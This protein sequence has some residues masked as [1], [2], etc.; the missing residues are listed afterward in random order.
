M[1]PFERFN[2]RSISPTMISQWDSAPVTLILRRVYGVKSK[3]APKMWRG[4][5]VEAGLQFWLYNKHR[6]D[7]LA[8]AKAL[9]VDTFWQR[10]A[11]EAT[12]EAENEVLNVPAMVEQAV[13]AC[14]NRQSS[15]MASQLAVEHFI[16]G[17]SVPVFGKMDF[18]FEDKSIIELKTTTR[19]PSSIE[20]ASLSHRWQAALYATARNVPVSLTYVTTKKGAAFEVLPG[21]PVL[22]MMR[23]SAMA[24]Q[25]A[26]EKC[27]DGV[28]LLRSLPL[29]VESFYWDEDMRQAYEDA[30]D[31]KLK[32]LV[33]P[34]TESLAS[35]GYVTFGKHAGK[36]ISELPATYLNW[37]LNPTLSDGKTFDVPEELQEAINVMR[38]AA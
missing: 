11:G 10:A 16:E 19:C 36:H 27:T 20:N 7:A 4:D 5:A 29:N 9:A 32:A 28:T 18:V 17:V 37:L 23:Q 6:D 8:N 34:G 12:E 31:G 30:L 3:A 38:E 25:T 21:D 2:I 26:L 24:L 1:N 35:Q 14:A 15:I 33:G 13:E 22:G